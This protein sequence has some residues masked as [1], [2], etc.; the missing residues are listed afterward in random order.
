MLKK[1]VIESKLILLIAGCIKALVVVG[2][3]KI[4]SVTHIVVLVN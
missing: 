3:C 4:P 2:S 1:K